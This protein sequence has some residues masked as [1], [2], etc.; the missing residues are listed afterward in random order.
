MVRSRL[1]LTLVCLLG[2]CGSALAQK[3]GGTLRITHR[4]NPPSASILEEATISTLMP[5]MAVFN[6]LVVFDPASRENRL[7]KIVPDLAK[8][9]AL[10]DNDRTLTFQLR[11][12]VK[13]HDGK[14]FTSADVK[15]TFDILSGKVNG[16]LRKNPHKTWWFNIK[17]IATNGDDQVVFH[18]N[19]PQPS[20]M[21]MFAGG[22]SPIY[23]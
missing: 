23:P 18:L 8:S 4:D 9:W 12:G 14:P 16:K 6:N 5:F 22:F 21:A 13:W 15:C 2:F 20:I 10:T 3:Q 17:D 1:W 11:D 19:D 7:D